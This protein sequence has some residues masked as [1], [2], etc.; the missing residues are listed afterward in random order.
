MRLLQ[1][2]PGS[3][4]KSLLLLLLLLAVFAI[5]E[6]M[7]RFRPQRKP[8]GGYTVEDRVAQYGKAADAYWIPLFQQAGVTYP[9]SRLLLIAWKEE[10]KLE[11]YAGD[12]PGKKRLIATLPILAASGRA[13]LKLREG[14]RQVPEGFYRIE[15]LNPNSRF[16]LSLRINYPNTEDLNAAK[17]EGRDLSNLGGD[18]MIHGSNVSVGCLAL[19]DEAAERLFI[20]A[21]KVPLDEIQVVIVPRDLRQISDETLASET[22]DRVKDLYRRLRAF[23]LSPSS[24]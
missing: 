5:W 16:H 2:N 21:A 19:G 7:Q 15:S 11:V 8:I 17:S 22:S 4:K 24:W 18:I 10:K 6:A 13:G 9:P 14:D 23:Q 20:L 3:L 12:V 1:K